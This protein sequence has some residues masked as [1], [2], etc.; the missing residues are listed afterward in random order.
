MVPLWGSSA[1]PHTHV[2][3]QQPKPFALF[4]G[5]RTFF[6]RAT[7]HCVAEGGHDVGGGWAGWGGWVQ[8]GGGGVAVLL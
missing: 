8:S 6:V 4:G 2:F 3:L 5:L 1:T 7:L